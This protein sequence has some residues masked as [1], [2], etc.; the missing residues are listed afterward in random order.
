MKL[1]EQQIQQL[2]Y[3]KETAGA[4]HSFDIKAL[5]GLS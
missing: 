2:T 3:E 4:N 5:Q 1:L